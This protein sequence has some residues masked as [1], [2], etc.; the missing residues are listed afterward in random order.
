MAS[1]GEVVSRGG[2][3]AIEGSRDH[4]GQMAI[5]GNPS[6]M[7]L[8]PLLKHIESMAATACWAVAYPDRAGMLAKMAL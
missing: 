7:R 3:L 8:K 5:I 6:E 1:P 2:S 4:H